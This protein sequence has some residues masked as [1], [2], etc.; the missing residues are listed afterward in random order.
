MALLD[1][2]LHPVRLRIVHAMSGGRTRTTS[3]LCARLPD[4]PKTSVYR[5]VG[6][7]AEGGVLEVVAEQRVHGAVE[8]HYRLRA[9]QTRIGPDAAATMTLDD[10]RRG[11]TATLAALLAEFNAYLDRP[12]ADPIADSIG[13]RQGILWL[14]EAELAELIKDLQQVLAGRMGNGPAPGRIPRLHAMISFPIE[15]PEDNTD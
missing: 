1:L 5:H 10:H 12:G 7:L 4:V 14:S 2:L 3:D 8:R 9:D 6:L 11:F 13:Y 15:P